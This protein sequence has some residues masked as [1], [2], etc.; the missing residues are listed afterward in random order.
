MTA[1]PKHRPSTRRVGCRRASQTG[2]KLKS[3][4]V[5]KHCNQPKMAGYQCSNCHQ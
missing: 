1:V 4:T 2:P 3:L 5:C